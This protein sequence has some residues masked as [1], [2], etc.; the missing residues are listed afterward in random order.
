MARSRRSAR[1]VLALPRRDAGHEQR[2]RARTPSRARSCT[3]CATARWRALGE[4]PFGRY[5]GSVDATPL[6][7]ML[8]GA[9]FQRTGDLDLIARL[10]PNVDCGPRLDRDRYG[11]PDGDGF[12]EYAPAQRD[13]PGQPGLEGFGRLVFHADGALADGADRACAR[14]RATSTR[15]S[16]VR[17]AMA[18]APGRAA[19]RA[20]RLRRRGRALRR[21]FEAAFWCEDLGDLRPGARRRQAALP[22]ASLERRAMPVDRHRRAGPRASASPTR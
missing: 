19:Q 7:V 12:V 16:G 17:R 11:D 2:S 10:W 3:R 14:C 13:R 1:G 18:R 15:P 8:A 22:R 4:V 20:A 21:S 9:Y 5:Y 6:F